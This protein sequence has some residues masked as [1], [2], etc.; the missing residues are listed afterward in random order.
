MAFRLYIVPAI[1]SGATPEDARR[2]KYIHALAPPGAWMDF[3]FNPVFFC[4]VDLTPA[5]HTSVAANADVFAFPLDLAA[6][7]SG[8][9]VN[10]RKA[11]LE[12]FLIPG[13]GVVNGMTEQACGRYVAGLFQFMQRLNFV[14][15]NEVFIDSLA[16]LNILWN[17]VPVDPYQNAILQAADSLGYDTSFIT[18]TTQVRAILRN[19]ADA[20]G[21]NP[22]YFGPFNL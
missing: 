20:W 10:T 3:G 5:Q 8:G 15:G 11:A 6:T 16:K 4:G 12:D 19:F 7:I 17:T 14:L 13:D 22:F 1:G 18:G 21:Q 9:A 2:P